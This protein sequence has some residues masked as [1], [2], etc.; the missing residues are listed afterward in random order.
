MKIPGNEQIIGKVFEEIAREEGEM[1]ST[2]QELVRIP[3]VV[4]SELQAQKFIEARLKEIGLK[5]ETFEARLEEVRQ[6]E[7]YVPVSYTY[8]NR[9]NVVGILEGSPRFR[10][11]ILNGHVDVVSPEPLD[12]WT[13]DPW[14]GQIRDG[15]LYGRGAFDMKGGLVANLFAVKAILNSGIKPGGTLTWQSVIEEEAG[16]G[17]GALACFLRGYKADGM[18]VPEPSEHYVW[19]QH[20][21]IKYF[22]V[23]VVGKTAHAAHSHTGVNAIGKMNKIYDAL[24]ALDEKRARDHR[25]PLVEKFGGR[26]CNLNVGIYS[27]GDW[28]SS[29][30]GMAVMDCRVGFVP[31]EKGKEVMKEVEETISQAAQN[32][33]WLKE[34]PPTVQWYGWNT[35]PWVQDE[36]NTFVQAFLKSSRQVLGKTPEFKGMTGAMDT[37]F[38]KYF[39]TPAFAFGP[40]GDRLH[41][42][43]EYV[44]VESLKTVT[45]VIAKFIL[46]WCGY[47]EI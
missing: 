40:R 8:A 21:G 2:A 44:D 16:G 42:P 36:K 9:P 24:I 6:H 43:D 11:L 13:V 37:R 18:L 45:R 28:A 5:V 12:Q 25:W 27:A 17:G 3:S 26:S 38:G 32:D 31:G 14:G 35:E 47:Q 30:A 39:G 1:I 46:D 10:S 23:R 41:G 22:R 34:H 4:G 29:V 7:T 33:P 19:V 20:T 15:K